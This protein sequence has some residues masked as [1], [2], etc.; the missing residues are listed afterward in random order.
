VNH[1]LR[2]D[3]WREL[4]SLRDFLVSAGFGGAAALLAAIIGLGAVLYVSRRAGKRSQQQL[5]QRERHH[6]ES[7]DDAEYAWVVD[8]AGIEP[9]ASEGAGLGLGPAVTLELLRG[10]LRE[11]ERLGDETLAKAVAVYQED[12]LLVLAQQGGPLAELATATSAELANGKT[13]SKPAT[14][15]HRKPAAA[16]AAVPGETSSAAA[17]ENAGRRRQ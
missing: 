12:L 1:V 11:A 8:T 7:R 3:Q 15:A 16:A 17:E 2:A 14:A 6:E 9:A 5:D 10:L 13:D 4:P